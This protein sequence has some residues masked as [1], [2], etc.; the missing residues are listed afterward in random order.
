MYDL[1]QKYDQDQ[2]DFD[3]LQTAFSQMKHEIDELVVD[4]QMNYT[5]AVFFYNF[6][7][8]KNS[9]FKE[10]RAVQQNFDSLVETFLEDG[11]L[12]VKE[13]NRLHTFLKNIKSSISSK[14]YDKYV[15]KIDLLYKQYKET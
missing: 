12:E 10:E 9:R 15:E 14:D 11:K 4:R 5:E 1:S 2:I 6:L 13:Y 8:D 3:G 7:E